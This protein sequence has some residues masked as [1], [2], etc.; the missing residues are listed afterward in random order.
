[1]PLIPMTVRWFLASQSDKL[2]VFESK[3]WK[4][5]NPLTSTK[6]KDDEKRKPA[7]FYIAVA[8]SVV[9]SNAVAT[10]VGVSASK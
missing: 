7:V 6:Q 9:A 3:G 4:L 8:T 2:F 5:L 10:Y 1:M